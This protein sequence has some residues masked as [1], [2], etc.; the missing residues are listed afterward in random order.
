MARG[1]RHGTRASGTEDEQEV[2]VGTDDDAV[3]TLLECGE[4]LKRYARQDVE[5][6]AEAN[7]REVAEWLL[8]AETALR[9]RIGGPRGAAGVPEHLRQ[10]RLYGSHGEGRGRGRKQP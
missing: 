9:V 1:R 5:A 7:A 3:E 4:R 2:G 10:G 6:K 8:R